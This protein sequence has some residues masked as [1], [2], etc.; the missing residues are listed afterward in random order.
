M[1]PVGYAGR[2]IHPAQPAAVARRAVRHPDFDGSQMLR[3]GG[4][5]HGDLG[6]HRVELAAASAGGGLLRHEPARPSEKLIVL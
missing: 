4:F 2:P 6:R 5:P 1:A 3:G